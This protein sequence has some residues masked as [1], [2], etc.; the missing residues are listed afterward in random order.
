[1]D[2]LAADMEAIRRMNV[3]LGKIAVQQQ[4]DT[5]QAKVSKKK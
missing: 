2:K 5:A 3:N 1:M 4:G